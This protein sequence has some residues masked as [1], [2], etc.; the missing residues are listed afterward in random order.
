MAPRT[1]WVHF[2]IRRHGRV[3]PLM[4]DSVF[5]SQPN[6][7]RERLAEVYG[8]GMEVER[9]QIRPDGWEAPR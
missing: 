3:L 9:V 7:A 1:R 8:P 4:F 5:T 2:R 6:A